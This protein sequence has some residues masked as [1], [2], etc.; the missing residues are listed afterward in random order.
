MVQDTI[1]DFIRDEI[2]DGD[3]ELEFDPNDDLLGT[4]ILASMEMMRLVQHLE[5]TYAFRVAPRDMAV[6]NFISVAAMSSYVRRVKGGA[7]A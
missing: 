6:E 7:N 3:P 5:Q 2:H 1:T 4:G